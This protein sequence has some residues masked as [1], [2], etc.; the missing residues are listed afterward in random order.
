MSALVDLFYTT[1]NTQKKI[2]VFGEVHNP[3]FLACDVAEACGIPES[4][5][6]DQINKFPGDEFAFRRRIKYA[7]G[8]DATRGGREPWLLTKLGVYMLINSRQKS[9]QKFVKWFCYNAMPTL[10]QTQKNI[11]EILATGRTTL[12]SKD[13][14]MEV[15]IQSVKLLTKSTNETR[16]LEFNQH[17]FVPAKRAKKVA[18]MMVPRAPIDSEGPQ[19]RQIERIITQKLQKIEGGECEVRVSGGRIDLLTETEVIEVKHAKKFM[20]AVGQVQYYYRKLLP[21]VYKKRVHLFHSERCNKK[22]IIDFASSLDVR[23]TFEE[24]ETNPLSSLS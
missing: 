6:Q 15:K 11:T 17:N 14:K 5:W 18:T 2:R 24:E 10:S 1:K 7:D 20:A 12:D 16:D 9:S 21:R 4:T 8:K 22:N 23:V 19:Y 3:I 13:F